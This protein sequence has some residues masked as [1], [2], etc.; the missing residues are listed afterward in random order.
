MNYHH[1]RTEGRMEMSLKFAIAPQ[2]TGQNQAY[3][4]SDGGKGR[5]VLN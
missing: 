1:C 3:Q 4:S 2:T 5:T